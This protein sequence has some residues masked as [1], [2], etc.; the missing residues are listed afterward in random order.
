MTQGL[1]CMAAVGADGVTPERTRPHDMVD[2]RDGML[3]GVSLVDP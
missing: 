1:A 2:E 3:L